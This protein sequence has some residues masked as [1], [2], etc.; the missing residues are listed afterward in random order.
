[1]SVGAR[2]GWGDIELAFVVRRFYCECV[3]VET[4]MPVPFYEIPMVPPVVA[5]IVP[6]LSLAI[7]LPRVAYY[8]GYKEMT[9]GAGV[10][11]RFERAYVNKWAYAIAAALGLDVQVIRRVWIC[12]TECI[13]FLS[14]FV[15]FTNFCVDY[16]DHSVGK[17]SSKTIVDVLDKARCLAPEFVSYLMD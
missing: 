4:A 17:L 2:S 5:G 16:V 14:Q 10:R 9:K 8:S 11:G 1:M 3:Y 12:D 6:P 15:G 7:R 13:G